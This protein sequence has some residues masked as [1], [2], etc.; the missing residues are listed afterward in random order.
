M[1]LRG[2]SQLWRGR[3]S[4]LAVALL[5]EHHLLLLNGLDAAIQVLQLEIYL[6]DDVVEVQVGLVICLFHFTSG[7]TQ[8]AAAIV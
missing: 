3:R 1:V 8:V 6:A 5:C 7:R 2:A 4:D